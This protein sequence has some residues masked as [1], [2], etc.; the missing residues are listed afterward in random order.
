MRDEDPTGA[1]QRFDL[2]VAEAEAEVPP[3]RVADDLGREAVV[4]TRVCG[5]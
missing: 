3:H 4:L 2:A 5:W 1:Q